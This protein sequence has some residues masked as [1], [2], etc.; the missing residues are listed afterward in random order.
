MNRADI[1]VL[2]LKSDIFQRW[3]WFRYH[4][5]TLSVPGREHPLAASVIDALVVCDRA[6]PGYAE[7]FVTT[8]ASIGGREKFEPQYEQ[9]LQLL[10]EL[11]IV[12]Q[13]VSFRWPGS[14]SFSAEPTAG[15]SKKNP[16]ITVENC[17]TVYGIEVKSPALLEHVRKR[18]TNRT[19]IP[20][21]VFTPDM[22]MSLSGAGEGVTLPR[23][24]P[25]KDFL[26]SANAKFA[27]F[28]VE[29]S[30]FVGVLVIVWDDFIYE[31]IS[32]V[33]HEASGLFTPNSFC[34]DELG[35]PMTFTHVDGV[36]VT[37]HLHQ[38]RR[39]TRDEPLVDDCRHP[40]DYGEDG[41]FPFKVF[42]ANPH[43][44]TVPEIILECLQAHVLSPEMGAAYAPTDLVWWIPF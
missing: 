32:S 16:E 24:N 11:H 17:G 4:F 12:H 27:S 28:K 26:Q 10:A 44:N 25:V 6:M 14:A 23:D 7:R 39:A 3:H 42:I 15:G 35:R 13:V 29:N 38:L 20:A 36:I 41:K 31:P 37:R 34:K 9:L 1:C 30:S 2:F 40:L 43:G 19:Q 21:R 33:V 5:S 18:G 8:L 22:V